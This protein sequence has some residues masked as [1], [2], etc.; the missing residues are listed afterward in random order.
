MRCIVGEDLETNSVT[1][2]EA[3]IPRLI[4]D[5]RRS[6]VKTRTADGQ[7]RGKGRTV[8]EVGP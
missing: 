1:R 4:A 8:M 7:V 5:S 3:Q 6:V 2:R